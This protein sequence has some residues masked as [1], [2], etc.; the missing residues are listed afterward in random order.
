MVVWK[1]YLTS[2]YIIDYITINNCLSSNKIIALVTLTS[3]SYLSMLYACTPDCVTTSKFLNHLPPT[4]YGGQLLSRH[5]SAETQCWMRRYVRTW[6]V[7]TSLFAMRPHKCCML[8]TLNNW[9]E[10]ERAPHR[11][12]EREPC[13]YVCIYIRTSCRK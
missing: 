7:R 4:D 12:V 13:L 11:R 6:Y 5:Q 1:Q 8:Y 2:H 9:G 3:N 10:P